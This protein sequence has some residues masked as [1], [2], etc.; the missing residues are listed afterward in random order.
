MGPPCQLRISLCHIR[1]AA[2]RRGNPAAGS[3]DHDFQKEKPVAESLYKAY[4]GLYKYDKFS[5]NPSVESSS[6]GKEWSREKI[7]IDAAYGRERIIIHLFLP[8]TSSL[9]FQPVVYFP[10]DSAFSKLSER[11]RVARVEND[12]AFILRS[13]RALLLPIYAGM[14]DR[15]DGHPVGAPAQGAFRDHQIAWAKD[16]GRS[17]DYLETRKDIDVTR[18]G[19][20]A[21]NAL[22]VLSRLSARD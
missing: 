8:K 17:L 20:F 3:S 12:A 15:D 19:Y 16:L 1:E 21:N 2:V 4:L 5:L 22:G 18:L 13:G 6:T 14:D 9:P 11:A 10:G 7:T